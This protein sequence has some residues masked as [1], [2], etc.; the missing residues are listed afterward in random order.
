[1]V[2]VEMVCQL[3]LDYDAIY[4]NQIINF[5]LKMDFLLVFETDFEKL[6]HL[7][8]WAITST[9]FLLGWKLVF[10]LLP[11]HAVEFLLFRCHSLQILIFLII[12]KQ[13]YQKTPNPKSSLSIKNKIGTTINFKWHTENNFRWA[14]ERTILR[15]DCGS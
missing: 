5:D 15:N 6:F 3:L 12:Q 14:F 4:R 10:L 11:Q 2:L 7:H 13:I 1:M 8:L 9:L